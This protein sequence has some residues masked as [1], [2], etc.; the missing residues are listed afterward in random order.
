MNKVK[1]EHYKKLEGILKEK[2]LGEISN[3]EFKYQG[4]HNYTYIATI[5][6]I[7]Y[8]VR[9]S[10]SDV[11]KDKK[12]EFKYYEDHKDT[13][14]INE[15][16]LVRKWFKGTT[17]DQV[18]LTEEIQLA[19]LSKLKNFSSIKL[20]VQEFNWFEDKIND[21]KYKNIIKKFL[22]QPT[23]LQH[24][25]LVLKNIL[26]NDHNEIEFIDLEW[27]RTNLNGFDAVSLY[28]QGFDK[29]LLMEYLNIKKSEFDDLL[30]ICKIFD[31]YI[32]EQN[33]LEK[34]Y[35]SMT[36]ENLLPSFSKSS[37]KVTD[38]VIQRKSQQF[39]FSSIGEFDLFPSIYYENEK[40]VLRQW[41]NAR[42]FNWCKGN[43]RRVASR[44][45]QMHKIKSDLKY[46]FDIRIKNLY[47][48][49]SNN[50]VFKQIDDQI[51]NKIFNHLSNPRDLVFSHNDLHQNNV[52]I[53]L[54]DGKVKFID[55][56]D[57]GLN[58]KYYDLAYLSSNL[59]LNE[60]RENHLL[61][62][63]D[64]NIDKKEFYKY[65]CIVNFCGLL[66]SLSLEDSS[67]EKENIN[68]ILKYSSY[69]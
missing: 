62:C 54:N 14:F 37:Y 63:Y 17:L 46:D 15:E 55:L 28:K 61:K 19:V 52:L 31:F 27:I 49:Y 57:A 20:Q 56:V 51:I 1:N 64:Q 16:I 5:N 33:Y 4:F 22:K 21:D 36:P 59:N 12:N 44:I 48:K 23:V 50:Q 43:I 69:L 40:I 35:S 29:K 34:L 32:Y 60:D 67:Q 3:F 9:I 41:V 38:K 10:K 47:Q 53:S 26:I 24:G 13:L 58:S 65:K 30:Y 6:N 45:K 68:N 39:Y 66:W 8:Q 11:F 2:N 18:K 7:D 25:D 42:V